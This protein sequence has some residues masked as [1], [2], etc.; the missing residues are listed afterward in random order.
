MCAPFSYSPILLISKFHNMKKTY[1]MPALQVN[2]A[3]V[4]NMMAVSLM[5]GSA[6]A[7][8][9]VLTKEDE[10]WDFWGNDEKE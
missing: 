1:M 2:E 6:D 8:G 4:Q 5:S 7:N 3:E 10:S 9:E